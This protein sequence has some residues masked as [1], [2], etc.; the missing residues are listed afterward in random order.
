M[1]DERGGDER[2]K[3][4]LEASETGSEGSGDESS[5]AGEVEAEGSGGAG[6]ETEASTEPRKSG[7]VE[8]DAA[9][10]GELTSRVSES[11]EPGAKKFARPPR[12]ISGQPTTGGS[13]TLWLYRILRSWPGR[14]GL[15]LMVTSTVTFVFFG[16]IELFADEVHP[17]FGLFHF[18]VLPPLGMVGAL[19]VFAGYLR[20]K[21]KRRLAEEDG[22][23]W[24]R[25]DVT[26][27]RVQQRLLLVSGLF[28]GVLVFVVAI[29][30]YKAHEFTDSVTFCGELCHVVMEPEFVAYQNSA[31]ARVTCAECHVG[32]GAQW[33]VRSK[34][35]GLYQVY[36]VLRDIYPRPIPTPI[37]SL[38]P[39]PDTCEQCH[40]PRHFFG[41]RLKTFTHYPSDGGEEPWVI[42]ML[43]N[44]GGGDPEKG[45]TRGIHWHMNIA[46][47]VEYIAR[48]E[49]RQ[50]IAW[51]RVLDELGNVT[52]Y[53]DVDNPLTD[54][55]IEE[56]TSAGHVRTMDCLDCHNRPSHV[57]NSPVESVNQNLLL[58][59]LDPS[60]PEIKL[61]AVE[62]LAA[63]YET[64]EEAA[65][66]ITRGLREAYSSNHP[67]YYA[68][69]QRQVDEAAALIKRI[70]SENMFPEMKVRWRAYP[71][72]IGHRND[73][74][75]FR[76]H[77]GNQQSSDGRVIST[78]CNSCHTILSQ[79]IRG[80][81]ALATTA[82][83]SFIHPLDGE[84]IDYPI[85]CH[86][87]H[88]GALGLTF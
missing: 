51:I 4:E 62:L 18:L 74:G 76:C 42:N 32:S 28:S 79:G 25:L 9:A 82:G 6:P 24:I 63:E 84:V 34:I 44:I 52:V 54:E 87:C 70:Y 17:Y 11:G 81:E 27:T 15:I 77:A 12:R 71:D 50:D 21:R 56:M 40:W 80:Q 58:G 75:C 20:E 19:L 64:K 14:V 35:S 26:R 29:G 67:E 72:D 5:G 47:A 22:E 1:I 83:S 23:E 48:D 53:Q 65:L 68:D 49:R 69:N 55:E 66:A 45:Y 59:N 31:H 2:D 36:A 46:N 30:G 10:W 88:D 57:F 8:G 3:E 61:L 7:G 39:A 33:Y 85:L 43:L 73:P 13:A 86:E 41:A 60:M 38:R 16:L 78:D 37:E